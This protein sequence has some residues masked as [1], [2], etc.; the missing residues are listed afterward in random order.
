MLQIIEDGYMF[1]ITLFLREENCPMTSL[2]LGEARG[3]VGF[4]LTKNHT[5]PTPAFWAGAPDN[6]T[7]ITSR[8]KNLSSVKK[9]SSWRPFT[10]WVTPRPILFNDKKNW[11]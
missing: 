11:P 3:S 10:D 8:K 1:R 4:L 2:T 5:V 7:I 6:F 9:I